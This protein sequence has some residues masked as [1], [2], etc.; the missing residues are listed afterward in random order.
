MQRFNS[1][2]FALVA[3]PLLA[4]AVFHRSTCSEADLYSD[5]QLHWGLGLS[6]TMGTSNRRIRQLLRDGTARW[7]Q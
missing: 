1:I 4:L 2:R 3:L 5:S 7:G 6:K